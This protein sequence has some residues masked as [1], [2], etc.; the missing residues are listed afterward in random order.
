MLRQRRTHRRRTRLQREV[1]GSIAAGHLKR[2]RDSRVDWTSGRSGTSRSAKAP[3]GNGTG[4]TNR[5]GCTARISGANRTR[6]D[7][8]HRDVASGDGVGDRSAADP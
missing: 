3:W 6:C 5:Q 2:S 7:L 1:F 8:S 4:Q